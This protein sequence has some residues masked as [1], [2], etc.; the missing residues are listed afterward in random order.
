MNS[1]DTLSPA[2]T[3]IEEVA[4][5]IAEA[6][7]PMSA[8]IEEH[9]R[10]PEELVAALHDSGLLRAG[11]PAEVDARYLA[12]LI[13]VEDKRFRSHHGVDPF[14]MLRAGWQLIRNRRVVSGGSTLTMNPM[15]SSAR[16][17]RSPFGADSTGL[18]AMVISALI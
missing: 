10:L 11:A 18:P 15:P 5:R 16:S 8:R 17:S 14:A 12:M 3:E 2:K 7:R 9:R 13:A 4:E 6:V 1:T